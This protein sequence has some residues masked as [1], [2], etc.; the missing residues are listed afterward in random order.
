MQDKEPNEEIKELM[1]SQDLDQET[2]ERVQA[3]MDE[4]GVDGGEAVEIEEAL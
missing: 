1:E 3:V 4:L 2:A